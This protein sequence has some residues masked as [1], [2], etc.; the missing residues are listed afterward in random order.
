MFDKL[1]NVQEEGT[2]TTGTEVDSGRLAKML[3]KTEENDATSESSGETNTQEKVDARL[4]VLL[5]ALEDYVLDRYRSQMSNPNINTIED[6]TQEG[7]EK[8]MQAWGHSFE[9]LVFGSVPQIKAEM[10]EYETQGFDV[11]NAHARLQFILGQRNRDS[12]A[13]RNEIE[14]TK[15]AA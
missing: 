15:E 13:D 7:I 12:Q 9:T 4:K 1:K 5:G 14:K 6:T 3:K 8:T 11:H 10:Q 2:K